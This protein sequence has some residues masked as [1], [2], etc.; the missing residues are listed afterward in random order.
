MKD[1]FGAHINEL[2]SFRA[3][4]E[5]RR[6]T[7]PQSPDK[8]EIKLPADFKAPD[9]VKFEFKA[10][11]PLLAQARTMAHGMGISQ[12]NFSKLL[13]LYAGAQVASQQQIAAARNAEVAK[14]GTT[15]PARIDALSTF[16]KAQL[17][18]AE[19]AQF[20]SRVFTAT[21]VQIAE[22]LV[23]KISGNKSFTTGGRE[24][25]EQQGKLSAAEIAKLS[26]AARLDYTRAQSTEKKM[27]DW[28]DPRSAAA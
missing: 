7:L 12:D 4:E 19:G 14:L 27:P 9:G 26:P 3:A 23:A 25:P 21:D 10:D 24:P 15:G 2:T 20:M 17:G 5:S 1:T 6:L 11:D 8:Y 13:G 28:K 22:K 16:F 18:D